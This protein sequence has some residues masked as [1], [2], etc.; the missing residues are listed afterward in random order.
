MHS[1]LQLLGDCPDR[2]VRYSLN[3]SGLARQLFKKRQQPL[4]DYAELKARELRSFTE[5]AL[6]ESFHKRLIQV[7]SKFYWDVGNDVRLLP[8]YLGPLVVLI[9]VCSVVL[10]FDDND[11]PAWFFVAL[12]ASFVWP[13]A[14]GEYLMVQVRGF[15]E[16]A[17]VVGQFQEQINDT[18]HEQ[19]QALDDEVSGRGGR[20]INPPTVELWRESRGCFYPDLVVLSFTLDPRQELVDDE[21]ERQRQKEAVV[22]IGKAAVKAGLTI[23]GCSGIQEEGEP[24]RIEMALN[25]VKPDDERNSAKNTVVLAYCVCK[26]FGNQDEEATE[27]VPSEALLDLFDDLAQSIADVRGRHPVTLVVKM[28]RLALALLS[29]GVVCG[30]VWIVLSVV[31]I[32]WIVVDSSHDEE[33]L[34][35]ELVSECFLLV[36]MLCVL[37]F[38]LDQFC[39]GRRILGWEELL[40]TVAEFQERFERKGYHVELRRES[41]RCSGC[42]CCPDRVQLRIEE[43]RDIND[44][45]RQEREVNDGLNV[46]PS[47]ELT[48]FDGEPVAS[49]PTKVTETSSLLMYS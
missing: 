2:V 3:H 34:E 44:N 20:S 23:K 14:M 39:C 6:F 1:K 43:S 16:M 10:G 40:G 12:I 7:R 33:P 38:K 32:A 37:V 31:E 49:P 22:R 21:Q 15:D 18:F 5:P 45:R 26:L 30:A 36:A 13:F 48:W 4:D 28:P 17:Q 27:L 35:L 8:L 46:A 25:E 47:T 42:C 24:K 41:S 9:I 19:Q 11:T 29:G